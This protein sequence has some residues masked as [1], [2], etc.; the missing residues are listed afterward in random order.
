MLTLAPYR[1]LKLFNFLLRLSIFD[2]VPNDLEEIKMPF[3]H[4]PDLSMGCR[5]LP[6][7]YL[8]EIKEEEEEEKPS[9]N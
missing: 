3:K 8:R 2:H 5:Q 6:T 1:L 4:G 9:Y 7:I